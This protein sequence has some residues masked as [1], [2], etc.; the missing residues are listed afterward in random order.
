[1]L[2]I[3]IGKVI[4]IGGGK[5]EDKG[6][7]FLDMIHFVGVVFAVVV[8]VLAA[9]HTIDVRSTCVLK[10]ARAHAAGRLRCENFPPNL[11]KY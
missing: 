3:T 2:F 6:E 9:M 5:V 11:T 4:I 1:M 7:D 8:V 10:K